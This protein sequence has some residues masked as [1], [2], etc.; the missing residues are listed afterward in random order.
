MM[1]M[2]PSGTRTRS[3]V[4]PFGRVQDS[5][6][7]PT[8]SFKAATVSMPDAMPSML[9]AI[10]R[11]AVEQRAGHAG[12]FGLGEV[13]GIG[14]K[15]AGFVSADGGGHA[16]QRLVF[17]RGGR[18]RQHAGGGA[19]AAADLGHDIRPDRRFPQCSSAAPS[20][21]NK[22]R[23]RPKNARDRSGRRVAFLPHRV[24][25]GEVAGRLK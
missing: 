10:E 5:V 13:F 11:E 12:G 24:R 3:M 2:T 9:G 23:K 18:E 7:S 8:G 15:D 20:S 14:G 21:S 17:L 25:P 4:M 19:R 22:T 16:G 6:T 1:P